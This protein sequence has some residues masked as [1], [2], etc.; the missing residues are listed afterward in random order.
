MRLRGEMAALGAAL[1]G[2]T[3][4]YEI[5]RTSLKSFLLSVGAA[6]RLGPW[7]TFRHSYKSLS[8]ARNGRIVRSRN[9]ADFELTRSKRVALDSSGDYEAVE[10]R[11]HL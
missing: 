1:Y 11:R 3:P 5:R 7:P 4:A 8:S 10:E 9:P 6:S 2:V